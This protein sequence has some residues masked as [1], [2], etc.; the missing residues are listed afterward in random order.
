MINENKKR[1]LSPLNHLGMSQIARRLLVGSE[2]DR[3][4]DAIVEKQERARA[5]LVASESKKIPGDGQKSKG[6]RP[7][8]TGKPWETEGISRQ[9]WYNRQRKGKPI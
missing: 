4:R 9:T 3:T 8:K 2:D 1:D 7:A 5:A 6:G